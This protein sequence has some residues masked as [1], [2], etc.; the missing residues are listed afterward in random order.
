MPPYIVRES[1]DSTLRYSERSLRFLPL[2]E[3]TIHTLLYCRICHSEA[4]RG[5][6]IA[7][8]ATIGSADLFT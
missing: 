2:V 5:I 4:K 7:D 3:K 8:M 6:A 1:S